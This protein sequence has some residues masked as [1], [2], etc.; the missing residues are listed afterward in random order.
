MRAQR[1]AV[2]AEEQ[3]EIARALGGWINRMKLLRAG[4]H[5]GV[6]LSQGSEA[7]LTVAIRQA[8]QRGCKLYVPFITHTRRR[9]MRFTPLKPGASLRPNRFG[10]LEPRPTHGG[11]YVPILRLDL[12][13]L[14]LVAVDAR[15]WRIG[16]GAG[17]YDRSLKHLRTARRWHRPKLIG[18]GFDFQLV[19]FIEPSRWDVPIDGLITERGYHSFRSPAP[20]EQHAPGGR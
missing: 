16:S 13:L 19:P 20:P 18:I 8:H 15:G 6:Y 5:V 2:S 1:R 17:F 7:R 10:I 9:V 14:P 11:R 12:I 4:R 3:R